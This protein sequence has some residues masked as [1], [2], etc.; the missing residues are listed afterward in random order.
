MLYFTADPYKVC[1]SM[2]DGQFLLATV[3]ARGV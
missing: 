2:A 3:L 1:F